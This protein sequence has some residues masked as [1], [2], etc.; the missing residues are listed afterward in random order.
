MPWQSYK[1]DI[2]HLVINEGITSVS[3]VSF[4]QCK[5]ATSVVLP[6]TL[7]TIGNQAFEDCVSL[8]EISF[9]S[10][11]KEIGSF[12]FD[13]CTSLKTITLP[14][15]L[16]ALGN[17]AFASCSELES[18]EIL[19]SITEIPSSVFSYCRKLTAIDYPKTVTR[20]GDSAFSRC[21]ELKE[22]PIT[23]TIVEIGGHAFDHC[24]NL[25]SAV[26]PENLEKL[27]G[28]AFSSCTKLESIEIPGKLEEI[29]SY[30]FISCTSLSNVIINSGVKK[31][32]NSS[33]YGCTALDKI[34]MPDSV[35]EMDEDAFG[36][37][38]KLADIR[39]SENL[40]IINA[41][42]FT[43]AA[44]EKLT[45]PESV[46]RIEDGYG[47]IYQAS[48][49]GK[50]DTLRIPEVSDVNAD[51]RPTTGAFAQCGQLKEVYIPKALT[52]IGFNGFRECSAIETAYYAGT[53][54]EWNAIEI[55]ENNESLQNAEIIFN[56]T[57]LPTP[58]TEVILNNTAVTVE[59]G[60]TSKLTATVL[61]DT[62]DQTVTWSSSNEKVATVDQSGNVKGVNPGKATITAATVNEL[63]ASCEVEVL[64]SDVADSKQYFYE[65]VYWAFENG[66]TVGAGGPG[67]FSPNASC[68]REQFVT[69]LWRLKGQ[70]KA[71][72]GCDFADVPEDAWYYEPI[73]WAAEKGITTGL[74]DGTNCFGVGQACTRE[75]CVTFLHRAAGTPEPEGS[76]EFT[77]SEEGR[78][79][80]NAI[81][82]AAGKGITVG[83]NDGTGRFGVGQ[84]CTR[85]MLVTF[86]YRS[87]HA[88]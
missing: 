9:P 31:I 76:I 52:Y 67:K 20:I 40:S 38:L 41:G 36:G 53:E 48:L 44:I 46:T 61:P 43:S 28:Y 23:E 84:K 11:L 54:E 87:A 26:L 4:Y 22:A 56:A 8:P 75:Q 45:L 72:E 66:I 62:A 74:N 10:G 59:A 21:I 55:K 32:G 18:V 7:E 68:T 86:L 60:K 19:S 17:T 27:G 70:P 64:F 71:T 57:G 85:G 88:D 15:S 51:G 83:L 81:K 42:V 6:E 24:S 12:A 16:E 63:T 78:Y 1:A 65:P 39:L 69:F 3:N 33:F 82:W 37:C 79:Y 58:A 13:G 29:G 5:N 35:I 49:D 73:S 77:D 47:P 14:S 50:D 80:Y 34:E 30:T 2:I 25:Q